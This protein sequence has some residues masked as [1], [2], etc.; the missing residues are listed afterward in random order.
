MYKDIQ[1][2]YQPY[3]GLIDCAM[4]DTIYFG[5]IVATRADGALAFGSGQRLVIQEKLL[6]FHGPVELVSCLFF[7]RVSWILLVIF[8]QSTGQHIVAYVSH[9]T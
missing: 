7:H 1:G 2:L 8:T 4:A 6:V 9:P 5:I 3:A